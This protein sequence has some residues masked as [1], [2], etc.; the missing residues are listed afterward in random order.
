VAHPP[1]RA[2]W[3]GA[4]WALR[5]AASQGLSF[6]SSPHVPSWAEVDLAL[7][8]GQGRRYRTSP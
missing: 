1:S 8:G 7:A 3:F 4:S 5:G 6:L 2:P